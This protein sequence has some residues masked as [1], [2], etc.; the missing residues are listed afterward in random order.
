MH[1]VL[2][3]DD[4]DEVR[5]AIVGTLR[6]FGFSTRE[7]KNGRAG[8][9]LAL[10]EAPDLI[11]CDVR[12]PELDGYKTL[13]AIRDIPAMASIPFIFLTGALDKSDMRRG[14]VS[15]ADDY[16]TK[17]FT[18]EELLDAAATRLARK[19]E[20]KCE[21]YKQAETMRK[22]VDHLLSR[23]LAGPLDGI[24]HLTADLLRNPDRLAPEKIATSA[25]RINDS[26]LRLNQL[27]KSLA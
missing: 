23:E 4:A 16:L 3:I 27:A 26:I 15:G 2:V 9:E 6:H 8:I 10:A 20:L 1:N 18:P 19:T 12:M 24:M 21:F 7:A 13:S 14:M 25:R 11:I 17:P 22:E 5:A